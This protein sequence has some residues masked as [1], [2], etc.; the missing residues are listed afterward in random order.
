MK[1]IARTQRGAALFV[2]L[3]MLVMITL[4]VLAG[5]NMSTTNLRITTNVQAREEATAAAQQ[6]IEQI[7]S[8]DFPANPQAASI[9]VH[10]YV[11]S[12]KNTKLTYTV[13]VAKPKCMISVPVTIAQLHAEGPPGAIPLNDA[14]QPGSIQAGSLGATGNSM[15]SQMTWDVDA[16]VTDTERSG[17][18]VEI[19]Q[20]IGERNLTSK[21]ICPAS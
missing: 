13:A 7:V 3:I 4:L 19:H 15:C 20:G 18:A 12:A 8:T 6:A 5:I 9:P 21:S 11:D 1:V 14:C 17:A 2:S 10:M 16:T